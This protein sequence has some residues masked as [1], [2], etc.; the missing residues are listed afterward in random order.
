MPGLNVGPDMMLPA[1]VECRTI[2]APTIAL[3]VLLG[4]VGPYTVFSQR[5]EAH[6]LDETGYEWRFPTLGD[7]L[8]DLLG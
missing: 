6:V 4:Q 1:G 2:G 5:T 3:R 7:A 8:T